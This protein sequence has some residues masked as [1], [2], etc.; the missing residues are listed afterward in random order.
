MLLFFISKLFAVYP[1]EEVQCPLGEDFARVFSLTSQNQLGGYDSDLASYAKGEQF[2]T[3]AISTCYDN[4]FSLYG[5]DFHITLSETQRQNVEKALE[6]AKKRLLDQNNPLLWERYEIAADI[7][8]ALSYSDSLIGQLYLEASWTVRDSFVGYHQGLNGPKSVEQVLSLGVREIAAQTDPEK[9]KLL[10]FNLAR[11]AHRGG[12]A[13]IRDQYIETF[14]LLPNL[15]S[16]DKQS[17]KYVQSYALPKEQYYQK[18]ALE[19]FRKALKNE[20]LSSKESTRILY[21]VA[22]LYRRLGNKEE[23]QTRYKKVHVTS[24]DTRLQELSLFFLQDQ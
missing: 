13:T 18:K 22:D 3:F 19:S 21:L 24:N 7:Y 14:L 16:K 12:Y 10:I 23:A 2:R 9:K 1:Y 5:K 17:M 6:K 8:Q 11:V 20:E 4:F 15:T